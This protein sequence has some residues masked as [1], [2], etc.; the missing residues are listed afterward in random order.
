MDLEDS[1]LSFIKWILRTVWKVAIILLWGVCRLL[2]VILAE[3]N[4]WLKKIIN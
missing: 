2:E 1:I 4:K 3:I